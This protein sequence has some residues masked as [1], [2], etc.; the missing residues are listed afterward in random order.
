MPLHSI[1]VVGPSVDGS[2]I[3]GP[4]LRDLLAMVADGPN[5]AEPGGTFRRQ[6]RTDASLSTPPDSDS[7]S[8]RIIVSSNEPAYSVVSSC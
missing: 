3:S 1:R 2:R 6:F 8:E 5:G 4:L 7:Q